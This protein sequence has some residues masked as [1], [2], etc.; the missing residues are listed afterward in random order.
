MK[1]K[2]YF[3]LYIYTNYIKLMSS[4]KSPTIRKIVK[5]GVKR[6]NLERDSDAD[7]SEEDEIKS[8]PEI[9][10]EEEIFR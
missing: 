4:T 1:T 2:N 3:I 10:K 6:N 9:E 7:T 5:K 8:I